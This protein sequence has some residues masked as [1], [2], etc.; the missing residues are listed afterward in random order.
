MLLIIILVIIGG[1]LILAVVYV[2]RIQSMAIV[3]F[4]TVCK[5]TVFSKLRKKVLLR[6]IDFSGQPIP[7]PPPL[8]STA[9]TFSGQCYSSRLFLLSARA[10][11][12]ASAT[13]LL[14]TALPSARQSSDPVQCYCSRLF[15]LSARVVVPAM[16]LLLTALPTLCQSGGPCQSYCSRLFLLSARSVVPVSATAHGS[17]YSP[18][19]RWF[20]LVLL[21]TAL[22]TLRQSS[23]PGQCYSSRLYLL[24]ARAVVPV[25]A[26]GRGSTYS[27][28]ERCPDDKHQRW[29]CDGATRDILLLKCIKCVRLLYS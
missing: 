17:T 28:L 12:P 25:S 11:V 2:I 9:P 4:S 13:A 3:L 1:Y 20:G 23:G 22:P 6:F 15:L 14:L 26:T 8:R 5:S 16:V 7:S 18:L 10:V 24:S 27:S 19:E 21:L 29:L